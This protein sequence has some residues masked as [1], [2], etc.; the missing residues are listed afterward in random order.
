MPWDRWGRPV[1][2][3][4]HRYAR[5]TKRLPLGLWM[6]WCFR[7]KEGVLPRFWRPL[8]G[9]CEGYVRMEWGRLRLSWRVPGTRRWDEGLT[10]EEAG[11]A[12]GL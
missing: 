1:P 10:K 7:P 3:R 11:I 12:S 5:W 4:A 6:E 9:L 2:F 8:K